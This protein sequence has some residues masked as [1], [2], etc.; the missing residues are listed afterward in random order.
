MEADDLEGETHVLMMCI[1]ESD[2]PTLYSSKIPVSSH[3]KCQ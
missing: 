2:P 3:R 1:S